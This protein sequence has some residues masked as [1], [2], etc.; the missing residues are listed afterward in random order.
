M[1]L[2]K[3]NKAI[4]SQSIPKNLF[5]TFN[6]TLSKPLTNLTNLSFIKGVFLNVL[7]TIDKEITKENKSLNKPCFSNS[8]AMAQSK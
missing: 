7:K 1:K 2:L 6:K 3:N 8:S 4:G 5:K